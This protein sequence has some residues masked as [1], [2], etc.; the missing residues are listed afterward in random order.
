[1]KEP[2]QH[3]QQDG[4]QDVDGVLHDADGLTG[5]AAMV[6]VK[7]AGREDG[8]EG[9]KDIEIVRQLKTR[10]RENKKACQRAAETD[11]VTRYGS[12]GSA[13]DGRIEQERPG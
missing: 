2:A 5:D 9:E 10:K 8:E 7:I 1:M 4:E 3:Q 13:Q 11:Q 6:C 12:T